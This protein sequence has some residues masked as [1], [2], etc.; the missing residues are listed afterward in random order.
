MIKLCFTHFAMKG[1][2]PDPDIEAVPNKK[3]CQICQQNAA[4]RE[5]EFRQSERNIQKAMTDMLT[6]PKRCH[7]GA[8]IYMRI[9]A[10]N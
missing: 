8:R 4:D 3:D 1:G 6:D 2:M 7:L 5:A 10:Q 9:T